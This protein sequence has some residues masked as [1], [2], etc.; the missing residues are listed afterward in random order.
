MSLV[1]AKKRDREEENGEEEN[2][3]YIVESPHSSREGEESDREF[4][5]S[6]ARVLYPNID[7]EDFSDGISL[8]S[9]SGLD[10]D[11]FE[12]EDEMD[13]FI[14]DD[15][16]EEASDEEETDEEEAEDEELSGNFFENEN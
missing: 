9:E 13:D 4:F 5:M 11:E 1:P 2:V 16:E 6:A 12:D 10:E 14:A 7:D 15:D 8:S 3:P